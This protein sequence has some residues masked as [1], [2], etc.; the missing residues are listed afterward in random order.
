[1]CSNNINIDWQQQYSILY[2]HEKLLKLQR[3]THVTLM[4]YHEWTKN[5]SDAVEN[6]ELLVLNNQWHSRDFEPNGEEM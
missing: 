1:M 5:G 4:Y 3:F 6:Q 2:F